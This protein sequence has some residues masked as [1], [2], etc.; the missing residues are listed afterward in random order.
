MLKK[1]K[2]HND[3][4]FVFMHFVYMSGN[5]THYLIL[6]LL[7]GFLENLKIKFSRVTLKSHDIGAVKSDWTR[8]E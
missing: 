2:M 7:V 6:Q 1:N 4:F 5:E 8:L 3:I